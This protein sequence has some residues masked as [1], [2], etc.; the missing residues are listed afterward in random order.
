MGEHHQQKRQTAQYGAAASTSVGTGL[1]KGKGKA[2]ETSIE[3]EDVEAAIP[4][5][6]SSNAEVPRRTSKRQLTRTQRGLN[7]DGGYESSSDVDEEPESEEVEGAEPAP[8][9]DP[10][11]GKM[12][13]RPPPKAA[14]WYKDWVTVVSSPFAS[15]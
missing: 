11:H 14:Y 6:R 1:D 10:T 4:Q 8:P 3:G 5:K 15:S 12:G 2:N 9:D 7:E 13:P